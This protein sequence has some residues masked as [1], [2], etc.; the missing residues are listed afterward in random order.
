MIDYETYIK[1]RSYHTEHGLTGVQIAR[2]LNM[3]SRTVAKWLNQPR[4]RQRNPAQRSSKLDPYK[5]QIL[6]MLEFYPYTAM[7]IFQRISQDGF[8]GGY[9]IV[10]DYVRKVRPPKKKAYLKLAFAPG[11]CAQVDWGS[12]GFVNVGNNLQYFIIF[13]ASNHGFS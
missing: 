11:E 4:Y 10:K 7:Q 2:K 5:D 1:I 6:R 3:D 8:D 13:R 9:T 12:Y